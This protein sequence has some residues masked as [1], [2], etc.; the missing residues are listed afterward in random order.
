MRVVLAARVADKGVSMF[1]FKTVTTTIIAIWM[2]VLA[3]ISTGAKENN[4]K[5]VV[6]FIFLTY[7]AALIGMWL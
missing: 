5:G 3:W 4:A 6:G 2:I 7:I 1:V